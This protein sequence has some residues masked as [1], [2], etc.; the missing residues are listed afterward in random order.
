ME[1]PF[2]SLVINTLV[3]NHH[4]NDTHEAS[5]LRVWDCTIAILTR[6]T[7][8]DALVIRD[9]LPAEML[10]DRAR[11]RHLIA[12]LKRRLSV[13]DMQLCAVGTCTDIVASRSRAAPSG[14]SSAP[15][16]YEFFPALRARGLVQVRSED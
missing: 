5:I 2:G 6:L 16:I 9:A 14:D 1:I 10:Q 8:V 11:Y 3:I 4:F 13:V 7:H 12:D 15:R